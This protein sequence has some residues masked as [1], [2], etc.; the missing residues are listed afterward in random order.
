MPRAAV[1]PSIPPF[2]LRF[3]PKRAHPSVLFA[4]PLALLLFIVCILPVPAA[5]ATEDRYEVALEAIESGDFEQ[6]RLSFESLHESGDPR[7]SNGLGVMYVRGQ[8]VERDPERAVLLFRKAAHMGLRTAQKNLGQMY[9]DGDGVPQ[10]DAMALRMFRLAA[11]RGD[12]DAQFNLGLM[13]FNGREVEQDHAKAME[14][15]LASSASGNAEAHA[16]VGHLYRGGYGVARNY[17]LAYAWY[18]LA[19]ALGFADG[20]EL[21]DLI[22]GYLTRSQLEEGQRFARDLWLERNEEYADG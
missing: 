11:A 3:L 13:H 8:G 20:P 9:L 5:L 1:R 17:V 18:G 21:R 19:A 2:P 14:W 7:G 6:A 10:D 12:P 4:R 22:A 16:Y 15:F